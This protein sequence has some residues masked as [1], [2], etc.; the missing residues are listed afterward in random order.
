MQLLTRLN[1]EQG[2]TI[3]M[4]THSDEIAAFA[5]RKVHFRDGRINSD[6][7]PIVLIA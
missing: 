6:N 3:V 2:L 7:Q 4:V 5:S 1:R